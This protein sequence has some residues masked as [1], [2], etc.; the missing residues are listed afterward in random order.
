MEKN[1]KENHSFSFD[2]TGDKYFEYLKEMKNDQSDES[3]FS[4]SFMTF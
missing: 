3:E 1:R 2:K 4:A